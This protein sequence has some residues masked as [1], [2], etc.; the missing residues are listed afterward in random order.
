MNEWIVRPNLEAD[1][2][3]P[4]ADLS[5]VEPNVG[6]HLGA[7]P[8]FDQNLVDPGSKW[9]VYYSAGNMGSCYVLNFPVPSVGDWIEWKIVTP[10]STPTAPVLVHAWLLRGPNIGKVRMTVEGEDAVDLDLYAASYFWARFQVGAI[11]NKPAA[12]KTVRFEAM[13]KNS[14][15]SNRFIAITGVFAV[16]Y[17]GEV[18]PPWT[19]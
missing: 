2:D 12:A 19:P 7:T 4:M 5:M 3:L 9:I 8:P 6:L 10:E 1:P 18:S 15:S 11:N 16:P 14:S 13:E 17:D